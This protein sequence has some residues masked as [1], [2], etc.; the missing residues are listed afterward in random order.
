MA[1]DCNAGNFS[2]RLP[3]YLWYLAK[4]LTIGQPWGQAP[5]AYRL[6]LRFGDDR[7]N[8][9]LS[10]GF[11]GQEHLGCRAKQPKRQ[12]KPSL[13]AAAQRASQEQHTRCQRNYH[14]LGYLVTFRWPELYACA[15]WSNS[16]E[17]RDPG[18]PR[19]HSNHIYLV[20]I[21]LRRGFK[22]RYYADSNRGNCDSDTC[23]GNHSG[24][25]STAVQRHSKRF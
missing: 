14:T 24:R 22:Q 5:R 23:I 19:I 2:Q 13:I 15:E 10:H 20:S 6:A 12:I 4:N 9:F 21:R 7:R 1:P 11:K 25:S 17:P 8:I 3:L 16:E 18:N